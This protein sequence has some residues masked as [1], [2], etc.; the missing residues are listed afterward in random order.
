MADPQFDFQVLREVTGDDPAFERELLEEYLQNTA[1]LLER[2]RVALEARNA[3]GL[4]RSAHS[5]KGSSLTL[6][7]GSLGQCAAEIEQFARAQQLERC[8]AVL[9]RAVREFGELRPLLE[10]HMKRLAA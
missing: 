5:M 2:Q 3:N 7:A 8:V 1:E 4:E 9:D 6:G 10:V